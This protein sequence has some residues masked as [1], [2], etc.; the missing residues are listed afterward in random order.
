MYLSRSQ[1]RWPTSGDGTTPAKM[2]GHA[3]SDAPCERVGRGGRCARRRVTAMLIGESQERRTKGLGGAGLVSVERLGRLPRGY[4]YI[5]GRHTYPTPT[6]RG[7][8]PK[9]TDI[10]RRCARRSVRMA[11]KLSATIFI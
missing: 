2:G 5:L 9:P 10:R 8:R 3:A 11:Q 1:Q 6:R 7:R 4:I